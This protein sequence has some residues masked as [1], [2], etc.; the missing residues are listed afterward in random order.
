[1]DEDYIADPIHFARAD[2]HTFA[3]Q[4]ATDKPAFTFKSNLP[5]STHLEYPIAT[6]NLQPMLVRTA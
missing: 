6:K 2:C 3:Q 4:A 5:C 1:M